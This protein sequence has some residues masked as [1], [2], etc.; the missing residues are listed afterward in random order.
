MTRLFPKALGRM[1]PSKL[2]NVTLRGFGGGWNTVADDISM[3]PQFVKVLK[4]FCRTSAGGQQIRFG[5]KWF[6]DVA[7]VNDSDIVDQTYFNNRLVNVCENGWIVTVTDA[8]TKAVIWNPTLCAGLPGAPGFWSNGLSLIT[9]VPHKNNLIIH[10]GVDKPVTIDS[11]FVVTYLQDPATGSNVNTPI[12][13]YAC[14]A[15]NYHCVAGFDANPTEVYISAEGTAGT[16]PGDPAPNDSISIEVGAYAPEGASAIRGIAGYRSYLLI[17]L[18]QV[19]LQVTLGI[20]NDA[21]VHTPK[22]PDTLPKFGLVGSRC[23]TA[24]END[25]VFGG[26]QGL[27]SAKRN[28]F[29]IGYLDSATISSLI[30]PDYQKAVG[31]LTEDEK[32]KSTFQVYDQLGHNL[33]IFIPD[34]RALVYTSN[35]KLQYKAWSEYEYPN[36]GWRCGC[37]SVLGRAFFALGT[38]I[39]QHGNVTFGEKYNADFMDN[40]DATWAQLHDYSEDDV[41][42]DAVTGASYTCRVSHTSP[43]SGAFSDSRVAHPTYWELYRGE[44]IP[45]EMELPWFDGKNPMK[46]KMLRFISLATKGTADFTISMWVD[47]LF[48]DTLGTQIYNPVLSLTF[49][50]NESPGFGDDTQYGPYGGVRRSNDPRLWSFPAKFKAAKFK[51]SGS[52]IRPLEIINMSFLFSKGSYWR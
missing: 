31:E 25:I 33:M 26:L 37:T 2:Q 43:A 8:G 24:I 13:K 7:D 27:T 45:F 52:T 1:K 42:G 39:F 32:Q 16:F 22:F 51:I 10:N 9:F 47:Y 18:Q 21:G 4:N 15:A 49:S 6:A 17:F 5:N 46:T 28:A 19:T 34:G 20:Y 11:S 12:G 29:A 40:R 41:A 44:E 35:E 48:E 38:K 14:I 36:P 23:I 30:E 3:P 50:G